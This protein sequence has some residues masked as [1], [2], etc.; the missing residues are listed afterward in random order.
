MRTYVSQLRAILTSSGAQH[1]LRGHPAGYRLL[2][3]H[4]ELDLLRFSTL[5]DAGRQALRS[6]SY[7][8]AR[9]L[10]GEALQ[11]WRSMPLP[12]IELGAGMR[13]RV[14]ALEEERWQVQRDWIDARLALGERAELL[15][16]LEELVGDRPLDESLW[17]SLITVLHAV[18]RTGDA[19]AAYQ[20][21]LHTVQNELGVQPGLALRSAQAGI[22]DG[23]LR[24]PRPGLEAGA[25][26]TPHQL[27]PVGPAIAGRSSEL[28]QLTALISA[29]RPSGRV[30]IAV[31]SGPPGIGKTAT[32]TSAA[33][34]TRDVYEDG[35]IHIDLAG[36]T[37]TPKRPGDA[38]GEILQAFGITPEAIPQ[39]ADRRRALY[40]SV[41][42]E[43][44]AL[45]ILDDAA[46]SPQVAD[47]L[48]G[49]GPS[50]VLI[51][52]RDWLAGINADLRLD[53]R[54]LNE[55]ESL[56]M[57]A[58]LI[59][60]DRIDA[61]RAA[62]RDIVVRCAML[63]AAIRVAG[64]RLS[65]RP[66]HTMRFLADRLKDTDRV[67]DELS[68]GEMSIRRLLDSGFERMDPLTRRCFGALAFLPPERIVP[69][70]VA[71]AMLQPT[72]VA[73]RLLER[74]VHNGLLR[75]RHS[76]DGVLTYELPPILHAYARICLAAEADDDIRRNAG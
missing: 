6:S 57:L 3:D 35:E 19:L 43:R 8:D 51:T 63:P 29:E 30:P 11:M 50:C 34:A 72:Q 61:E 39:S 47:L 2:A 38:I 31:L 56:Q 48:P 42:A 53:L 20:R 16:L 62:A 75:S 32:A 69:A 27:L 64:A 18:G 44:R 52:S 12:E 70:A 9:S 7:N 22:L 15:P 21:A 26:V 71:D 45:I 23:S 24:I 54:P 40:R 58:Q 67:L 41:L 49:A 28:E 74:L 25:P 10:L 73:D 14:S 36:S 37:K 17:Y 60:D 4:E 1:R 68:V 5:A 65:A 66:A 33:M 76:V 55:D 46:S 59:G 13:A